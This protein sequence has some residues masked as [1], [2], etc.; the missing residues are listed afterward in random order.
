MSAQEL[1]IKRCTPVEATDGPIGQMD[2]FLVDPQDGHITHLIMREGHLWD[3]KEVTL[4]VS[5][6]DLIADDRV[7]LKLDKRSV[8]ALP[9]IPVRRSWS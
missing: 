8:A 7:Y 1:A 6:I 2:E 5:E 4:A 3:Q 9:A